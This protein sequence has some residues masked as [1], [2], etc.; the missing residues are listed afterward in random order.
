MSLTLE[1][2]AILQTLRR[3]KIPALRQVCVEETELLVVLS[4]TVPSYYLKQ[5]AQEAVLPL[6]EKRRL[7]NNVAVV[8]G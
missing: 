4:G 2:S 3:S 6:C 5:M 7:V 8:R 1:S